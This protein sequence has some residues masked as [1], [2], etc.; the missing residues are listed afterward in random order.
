MHYFYQNT[1][2]LFRY[3]SVF[4]ALCLAA[5]FCVVLQLATLGNGKKLCLSLVVVPFSKFFLKLLS[6]ERVVE[7]NVWSVLQKHKN[8]PAIYISNHLSFLDI[9]AIA[10]LGVENIRY[11][12][13][14]STLK[15]LPL[16]IVGKCI[17]IFYISEQRNPRGRTKCF[18]RAETILAKEGSSVY[19]SPE[20]FRNAKGTHIQKFNKGAF[21]MAINLKLPIVALYISLDECANPRAG[22]NFKP[23]TLKIEFLEEFQSK[24]WELNLLE[25]YKKEVRAVYLRREE[26][27]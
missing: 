18:Q 24:N 10:S 7:D 21:H 11:F 1:L 5:V 12:M 17:G 3:L 9:F 6:I 2:L 26:G 15:F 19:L 25:H 27:V 4:L 14:V 22:Y 20:G 16:T 13:S 8:S 23:G